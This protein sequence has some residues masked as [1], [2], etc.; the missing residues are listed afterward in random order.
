MASVFT[1]VINGEFPARFVYRDERAV[2]FLTI[3]PVVPGHVLVVP[4]QEVD[5]WI[6]LDESTL[7]HV[8]AV[9]QNIG[10]ALEK[11]FPC[12]K[13]GMTIQGLEVPHV[14]VHLM[15][16][17]SS[18]DVDLSRADPSPSPELLDAVQAKI[19]AALAGE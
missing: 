14:H 5:H 16:I 15:P 3:N 19:I 11:A 17:N 7:N 8:M 13:I 9:S 12:E 6:D 2:A 10:R 4:V 18:A 1:K